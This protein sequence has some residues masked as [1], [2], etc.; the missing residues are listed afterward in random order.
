MVKAARFIRFLMSLKENYSRLIL[1]NVVKVGETMLS[2]EILRYHFHPQKGWLNDP[3]GLSYFNGQYHVFFQYRPNC[4]YAEGPVCWGHAVTGDFLHYQELEPAL[5]PEERYDVGGVW[6]GTA[7]AADGM[8]YL[9]YASVDENGRQTIS[10]ASSPDGVHFTK[11]PH[12]PIIRDYPPDGSENFR[13]PAVLFENG[14]GRM[15]IASAD[16]RKGTGNLLLYTSEDMEHW[17]YAGVLAEYE[18]C[19][20][21]ECPSLVRAGEG[22]ILSAS[23]CPREGSRYFEV[24]Y[25]HFEGVRF[26][27]QIVSH[28]QKGP[29]EY[30]G[31]IFTAPDG[32][33]ILISWV[34]GWDYQPKEKC[35][36]CL[37]LPM[38][39]IVE[40][41]EIR[42]FP[43]SEVR[44][45]LDGND[46]L[47]DGYVK[48]SFVNKGREVHIELL[49]KP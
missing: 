49:Q 3:N 47:I 18:N 11:H 14:V 15:V 41:G 30:A 13:D 44:H 4:E 38:E 29:D 19:E 22:Y 24:M 28:F 37:S 2:N 5:L 8:L 26:V 25:G 16:T 33:N 10:M 42:A 6:S 45:L 23:V 21:C 46:T 34:S 1:Y 40:Q 31:Q 17:R 43:I 48:E 27:P 7:A 35:I 12:N 20:F 32:R 9:Y 36:G 39:V